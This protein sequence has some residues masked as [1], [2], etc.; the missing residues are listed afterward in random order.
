MATATPRSKNGSSFILLLR[1][2]CGL[3]GLEVDRVA[4]EQEL[5][6]RSL[7]SAIAPPAYVYGCTILGDSNLALAID[8][9]M[10]VNMGLQESGT[11]AEPASLTITGE[12]SPVMALSAADRVVMVVDDSITMRQ[13]LS[14]TL[15]RAGYRVLQAKDGQDAIQQL[16]QNPAVGMVISDLEMP[17]MNGLELLGHCQKD[18]QLSQIPVLILTS[19]LGEQNRQLALALGAAGYMNKPF[20]ESELLRALQEVKAQEEN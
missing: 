13:R 7:G 2:D 11:F 20:V 5:V 15:Q 16:H 1:S 17:E 3:V 10:L 19:N 9:L 8:A 12:A 14:L 4:G 6:I 18:T